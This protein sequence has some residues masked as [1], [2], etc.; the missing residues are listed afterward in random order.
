MPKKPKLRKVKLTSS[1][2]TERIY[3]QMKIGMS[4]GEYNGNKAEL[5]GKALE[6]EFKHAMGVLQEKKIM[7]QLSEG[8]YFHKK[9]DLELP[10]ELS[11]NDAE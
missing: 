9:L 4:Y 7:G 6:R 2:L 11:L 5:I 1:E 8:D 3:L 10:D